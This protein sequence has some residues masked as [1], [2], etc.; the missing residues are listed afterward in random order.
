[1]RKGEEKVEQEGLPG[2]EVKT[3]KIV[4]VNGEQNYRS[5]ISTDIYA[6]VPRVIRVGDSSDE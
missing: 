4:S 2:Y 6:S 5:V 3:V 1:M